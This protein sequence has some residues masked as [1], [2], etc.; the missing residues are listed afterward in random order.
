MPLLAQVPPRPPC[1]LP[2]PLHPA[3]AV[4]AFAVW[5]RLGSTSP[6]AIR[7]TSSIEASSSPD[8]SAVATRGRRGGRVTASTLTPSGESYG[9]LAGSGHADWDK[10]RC[11]STRRSRSSNSEIST[12]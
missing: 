3:A 10:P 9:S 12:P 8:K 11:C 5:T 6:A 4:I 1:G 2:H 7:T